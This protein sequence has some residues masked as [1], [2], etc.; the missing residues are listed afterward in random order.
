MLNKSNQRELAYIV[1]VTN[2][3]E[4]KG[5]NK[6]HYIT[7]LGWKCVAP[8]TIH[9]GDKVVY[10]EVDSVLPSDDCRFSFLSKNKFRIK[11]IRICGVISQGLVMPL[12]DFPEIKKAKAGDFLTD[13]LRVKLYDADETRK[14]YIP[15]DKVDAFTKA[16]DR[17][18]RFFKNPIIKFL[19]RNSLFRRLMKKIFI[20]KKDK[21][22][23]PK[24]LPKTGAERIQNLPCLFNDENKDVYI[25]S[26][27]VDGM[28]SSFILDEKNTYMVGSHNVI[29]YSSKVKN[30]EK[31][32]D[33]NNYIKTN[34]WLEMSDKYQIKEKL[35]E[36]KN[37]YK[38]KSVVI[39]GEVFGSHI[40]KRD[41]SL[42]HDS[43]KLAVFHVYFD[44][45]ILPIKR[46]IEI[47]EEL[48]L[49]HVNIFDWNYQ[50]PDTV[51]D[52][53]S[54]VDSKKSAID[55]GDIEGFVLYTQ[56]GQQHFKCVSPS[57]LIKYHN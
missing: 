49:L 48:E 34:V 35:Y 17:H 27:K 52:V 20:H 24:W 39:Q 30:S 33:G 38:L 16:M 46:M 37:K 15:K 43:H 55:G 32:A 40:Q 10:F 13:K 41:Y 51:E 44:E 29:V 11:P 18:K 21:I 25:I 9:T 12:E 42:K 57:Y 53:I 14:K 54:L 6:V 36:L 2:T 22:A 5:Y 31:I 19:M 3:E 56:D 50:L 47:C 4:L 8:T 28:S 45:K 7:V 1:E 26:E 23:W